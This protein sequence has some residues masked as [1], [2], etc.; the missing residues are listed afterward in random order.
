MALN[1]SRATQFWPGFRTLQPCHKGYGVSDCA[2]GGKPVGSINARVETSQ[3]VWEEEEEQGMGWVHLWGE[4]AA[5]QGAEAAGGV[6]RGVHPAVSLTVIL[7][8]RGSSG[9]EQC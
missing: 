7:K 9:A 3:S 5:G 2:W 1:A 4:Q 8:R 6:G